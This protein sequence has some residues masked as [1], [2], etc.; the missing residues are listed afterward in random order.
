ML[1]G[2]GGSIKKRAPL[3]NA[4]AG[5]PETAPGNPPWLPTNPP[6]RVDP[7]TYRGIF[8]KTFPSPPN[9]ILMIVQKKIQRCK[10]FVLCAKGHP[11]R[12]LVVVPIVS[13]GSVAFEWATFY[14]CSHIA[15]HT[16]TATNSEPVQHLRQNGSQLPQDYFGDLAVW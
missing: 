8:K 14:A 13:S 15:A 6:F 1:I 2:T 3:R 9:V 12:R 10:P 4:G 5:D 16:V 11:A 7:D